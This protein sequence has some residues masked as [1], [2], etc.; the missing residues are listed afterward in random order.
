[1]SYWIP[2]LPVGNRETPC[3][4]LVFSLSVG[5]YTHGI[6][7]EPTSSAVCPQDPMGS[8]GLL[9]GMI[10]GMAKNLENPVVNF[11][12]EFGLN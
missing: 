12:K 3:D 7:Q 4:F 5:D 10:M 2:W 11:C 1:M 8:Y 6:P 9:M